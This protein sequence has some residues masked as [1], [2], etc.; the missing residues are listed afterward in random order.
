MT[1]FAQKIVNRAVDKSEAKSRLFAHEI[2]QLL[3]K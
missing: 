3:I 2:D 1:N